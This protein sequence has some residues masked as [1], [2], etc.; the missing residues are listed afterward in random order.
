[1]KALKEM[2][3]KSKIEKDNEIMND[4]ED[5]L[6]QRERSMSYGSEGME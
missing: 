5:M 1:M 2:D 4:M 3:D 6:K